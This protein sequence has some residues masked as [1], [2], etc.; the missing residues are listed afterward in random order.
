MGGNDAQ[1]RVWHYVCHILLLL[2]GEQ[3]VAFYA[4][5]QRG[6]V[7]IAQNPLYAA[8]A[9]APCIVGVEGAGEAVVGICAEPPHKFAALMPLI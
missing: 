8:A 2:G 1:N 6:Y 5:N 7:D 4:D 9:G 3:N